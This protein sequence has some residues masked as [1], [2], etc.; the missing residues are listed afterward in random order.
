MNGIFFV[1]SFGS[2]LLRSR[3]EF[4]VKVEKNRCSAL[5]PYWLPV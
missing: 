3:V 2:L 1:V 4:L 5:L